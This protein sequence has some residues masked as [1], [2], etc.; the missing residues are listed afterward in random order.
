ME[1]LLREGWRPR[2]VQARQQVSQAFSCSQH[3]HFANRKRIVTGAAV[4]LMHTHQDQQMIRRLHNDEL[5][6]RGLLVQGI[7]GE[8]NQARR[9]DVPATCAAF[10]STT[11]SKSQDGSN[12]SNL[13][14]CP[15]LMEAGVGT[16]IKSGS[17]ALLALAGTST[18]TSQ[19]VSMTQTAC[20]HGNHHTDSTHATHIRLPWPWTQGERR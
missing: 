8:H 4:W 2:G 7:A 15:W 14:S 11:T 13:S 10:N 12:A 18:S 5:R 19:S 1:W 20:G 9:Q 3:Q 17:G 16:P 6:G